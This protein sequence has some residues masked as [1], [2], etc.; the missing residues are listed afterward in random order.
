[1][2]R[3]PPESA[4]T[5][6]PQ[7]YPRIR[8][9]TAF[10]GFLD[11]S[12]IAP[13]PG[14]I[15]IEKVKQAIRRAIQDANQ[16]SSRTTLSI[17]SDE[18]PHK[19]AQR[20]RREGRKLL[21][22]LKKYCVDPAVTA[23][24]MQGKGVYAVG[25][26]LFR[27]RILQKE[28]MNAGWRYQYLTLYCARETNR[29]ESVSDIG[30][31]EADFNAT[32]P[33]VGD[34]HQH[35]NLFVSV[36]NRRNTIGGQD[37]PKAMRALEGVANRDK[38]RRGP[39]LCVFGIAMDGGTR[40]IRRDRDGRD[41]SVNTEIWL[42]DYFWP[43]FTNYTYEE[44]MI[45][46]LEV[47]EEL[48]EGGGLATQLEVPQEILQA[49]AEACAEERLIDGEGRFVNARTLVRF[50]CGASIAVDDKELS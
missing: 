21:E 35:L 2:A 43:F 38:N 25:E 27:R 15:T 22:Y 1:M 8:D 42:S 10:N 4:K 7:D 46:V 17:P 31:I 14:K 48:S 18:P 49:F 41:Y 44:L 32:V 50:I 33:F 16:K 3:K 20:Y 29:F 28:R 11:D 47:L 37:F 9:A 6:L 19:T 12:T 45:L 24:D 13:H 34:P 26:D 36:K 23:Y 5:F 39:Y 30:S 40:Q